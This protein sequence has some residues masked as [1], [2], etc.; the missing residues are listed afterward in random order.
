MSQYFKECNRF[1]GDLLVHVLFHLDEHASKSL[2]PSFT[3]KL[4][5]DTKRCL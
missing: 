3:P 2:I 5:N 4:E 1:E